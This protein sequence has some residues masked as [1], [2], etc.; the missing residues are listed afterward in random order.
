M[1][2]DLLPF[3]AFALEPC[4]GS[5]PAIGDGQTLTLQ[6]G[7]G[8][9]RVGD[10]LIG[11]TISTRGSRAVAPGAVRAGVVAADGSPVTITF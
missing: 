9:T 5:G 8:R 1:T 6:L 2:S 3:S 4:A 10:E 7:A 11:G